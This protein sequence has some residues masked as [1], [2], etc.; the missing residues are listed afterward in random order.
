MNAAS[1]F[2]DHLYLALVS[3]T[4]LSS[5]VLDSLGYLLVLWLPTAASLDSVLYTS[6]KWSVFSCTH[7][8]FRSHLCVRDL[9]HVEPQL[10]VAVRRGVSWDEIHGLAS[11]MI[12]ALQ[13]IVKII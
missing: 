10:V 4:T 9:F 5:P 1:G 7:I 13:T 3:S 6:L 12:C 2:F 11:S 8:L